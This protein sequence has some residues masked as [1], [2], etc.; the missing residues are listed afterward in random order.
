[1]SKLENI[2]KAIYVYRNL[3][4]YTPLRTWIKQANISEDDFE[5]EIEIALN[6][7]DENRK[8]DKRYE[9]I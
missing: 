7:Y 2:R 8:G 4:N 6:N 9:W 5:K 3:C 1:M